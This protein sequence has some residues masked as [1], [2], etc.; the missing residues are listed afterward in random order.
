MKVFKR[1]DITSRSIE[2]EK[3]YYYL[4]P[5]FEFIISII[6]QKY[7]QDYH[8][9]NKVRE[10]I[11]VLGGEIQVQEGDRTQKL[12]I[13]EAVL[14]EPSKKFQ[15]VSNLSNKTAITATIKTI[16]S[17]LDYRNVFKKDKIQKILHDSQLNLDF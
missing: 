4:F 7:H 12:I 17:E 13:E 15:R 10:F 9:H 14:F 5:D 2:E 1:R 11:V 8:R 6:P 3:R 16:H